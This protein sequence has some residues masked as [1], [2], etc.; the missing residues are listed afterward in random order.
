MSLLLTLPPEA[1]PL[2]LP[3]EAKP[4][5]LRPEPKPLTLPPSQ[6]RDNDIPAPHLPF[7]R[8]SPPEKPLIQYP[9][10]NI[11]YSFPHTLAS[12]IRGGGV[13][14]PSIP[15]IRPPPPSPPGS[16]G[17]MIRSPKGTCSAFSMS[18]KSSVV[19]CWISYGCA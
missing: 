11:H 7:T 17:S 12:A 9:L 8:P 1:K 16:S 3:P 18:R 4:L 6:S 5:T 10:L 15:G 2:T 13:A 14:A 19:R